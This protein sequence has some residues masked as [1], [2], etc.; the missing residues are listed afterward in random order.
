[1]IAGRWPLYGNPP[2]IVRRAKNPEVLAELCRRLRIPHP[3][4]SLSAPKNPENW[5]LKSVGG[6][7]GGHVA[8]A[9]GWQAGD[10]P[11]YFQRFAPGEPISILCLC[12]GSNAIALGASRQW[13]APAPGE[14]FRYGGCVRP[15]GLPPRIEEQ[16]ADA[17]GALACE[18][19]L[20]GLNSFDFLV[21]SEALALIEIN[22][23]PG[24]TLDIF[25]DRQGQLF[26]AHID[27]CGGHLARPALQF[28]GAA[29]A[30]IAYAPRAIA[31]MPALVWPHWAA[32][33]QRPKTAVGLYDPLCTIKACSADPSSAR[34]LVE[35]R[36]SLLLKALD[37]QREMAP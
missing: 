15:A 34:K 21:D 2:E 12:D 24:A 19:S 37:Q 13:T 8:P 26:K 10:E 25:E 33:R 5:L 32:D 9:A 18:L 1:M 27:A 4:V 29:A 30:A 17:A 28:V 35:E 20:V 14:P 31:S 36:T 22:P 23:R 7:G 6:A 3:E 16:L 11:V